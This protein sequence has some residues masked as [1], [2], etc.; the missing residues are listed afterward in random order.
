VIVEALVELEVL[1]DAREENEVVEALR[2]G[3]LQARR[4]DARAGVEGVVAPAA[5]TAL[6]SC[7]GTRRELK[8]L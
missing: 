4:E 3:V 6:A 1:D 2:H 8:R 7:R 5:G